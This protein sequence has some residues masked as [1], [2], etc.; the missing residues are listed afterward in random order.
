MPP[1]TLTG[2]WP[3]PHAR[4][5]CAPVEAADALQRIFGSPIIQRY[6]ICIPP[7]K[8]WLHRRRLGRDKP[9]II[10]RYPSPGRPHVFYAR[11]YV[12]PRNPR[13]PAQ[14][15]TRQLFG[16]LSRDWLGL[17]TPPQR[18]AWTAFARNCHRRWGPAW[19]DYA[20]QLSR[21][22][23]HALTPFHR[24][25]IR[26]WLQGG[27]PL[28]GPQTYVKVNSVLGRMGR[29]K[30]LWPPPLP[31]PF[32]PDPVQEVR[33]RWDA[34]AAERQSAPI[35]STINHPQS[36]IQNP[37]S[38]ISLCASSAPGISPPASGQR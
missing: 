14:V 10:V 24:R 29:P 8:V 6:E 26:W 38:N 3:P 5:V 12:V 27:R 7:G 15:R 20:R 33:L 36:K 9:G 2:L 37:K 16:A 18:D 32:R 11:R 28:N 21:C 17:L 35:R 30:L 34:A 13:T 19:I 25:V 23:P 22:S 31:A 1:S 4:S